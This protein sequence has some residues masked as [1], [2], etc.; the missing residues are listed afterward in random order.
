MC[1]VK[2][3]VD[4]NILPHITSHAAK[5]PK[6]G[7]GE[8]G[9]AA[10]KKQSSWELL[11]S[12]PRILN[13]TLM[14]MGYGICHK[15]FTFVWKGQMRLLCPSTAAYATLMADVASFTGAATIALMLVSKFVFQ[16]R[17]SWTGGAQA[18]LAVHARRIRRSH[19]FRG[20][21]SWT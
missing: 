2:S 8:S 14:V 15:L 5:K 4:S 18:T 11:T 13:M 10:K 20:C 17:H 21:S 19:C 9:K 3:W 6:K 7:G 12:S 16:V 1:A